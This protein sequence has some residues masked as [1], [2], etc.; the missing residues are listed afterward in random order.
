MKCS[1]LKKL[2]D[3]AE[4][5]LLFRSSRLRFNNGLNEL[6]R[7]ETNPRVYDNFYLDLS[8]YMTLSLDCLYVCCT[9]S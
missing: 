2:G 9:A 6:F 1:A 3:S 8:L 4:F 5:E 7:F